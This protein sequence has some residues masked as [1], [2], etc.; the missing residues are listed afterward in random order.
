MK[1]GLVSG[2]GSARG[3]SH[4]GFIEALHRKKIFLISYIAG[5]SIGAYVSGLGE[6]ASNLFF[7]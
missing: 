1:V 6:I 3:W 2:S 5:T 7:L 4:I